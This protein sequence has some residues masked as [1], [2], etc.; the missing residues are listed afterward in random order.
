MF[1]YGLILIKT[2]LLTI[3]KSTLIVL[4]IQETDGVV[5]EEEDWEVHLEVALDVDW[6]VD[7][8]SEA[9]AAEAEVEDGE[10]HM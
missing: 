6:E 5:E 10:V 8:H 4:V 1:N 7:F 3:T 9:G 2:L